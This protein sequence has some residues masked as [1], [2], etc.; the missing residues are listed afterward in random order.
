M[1]RQHHDGIDGKGPFTPCLR[2]GQAQRLDMGGQR[3]TSPLGQADGEEDRGTGQAWADV[4]GLA[5]L[6]ST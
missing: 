5:S 3:V 6:P 4:A 2:N 1:V